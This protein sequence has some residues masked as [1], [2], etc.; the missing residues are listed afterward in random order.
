MKHTPG[1]FSTDADRVVLDYPMDTLTIYDRQGD[2]II[3]S[4]NCYHSPEETTANARLFAAA[5][6][7]LAA[8]KVVAAILEAVDSGAAL[9][10]A[11]GQALDGYSELANYREAAVDCRSAIAKVEGTEG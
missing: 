4:V 3:A 11:Q 1:P 10:S 5:P 8:C 7:L 9:L 2:G 6:D